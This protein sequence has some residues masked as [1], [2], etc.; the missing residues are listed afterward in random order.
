[1]YTDKKGYKIFLSYKEIQ[2]RAVAQSSMR[3]C[4]LLYEEMRKYLVRPLVIYDIVTAPFWI[5][6][7]MRKLLFSV[8][9]VYI[10]R[11]PLLDNLKISKNKSLSFCIIL[12]LQN[13]PY[14]ET[15]MTMVP[16]P[17][18]RRNCALYSCCHFQTWKHYLQ[19]FWGCVEMWTLVSLCYQ[20]RGTWKNQKYGIK[21][22]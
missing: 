16:W 7:Y 17:A 9:S 22:R 18:T 12:P 5:S 6:L 13:L 2:I 21:E 3:K 10:R 11:T 14:K 4:F 15:I 20:R 19:N 1:M 8:L